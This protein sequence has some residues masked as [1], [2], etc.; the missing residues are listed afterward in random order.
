[1]QQCHTKILPPLINFDST[2]MMKDFR[3][4][5]FMFIESKLNELDL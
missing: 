2:H 1:M 3:L 4:L 5:F